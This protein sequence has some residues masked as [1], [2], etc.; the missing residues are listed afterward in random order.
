MKEKI[1]VPLYFVLKK[2][3]E[4]PEDKGLFAMNIK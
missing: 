1:Q 4:K 2:G 3:R